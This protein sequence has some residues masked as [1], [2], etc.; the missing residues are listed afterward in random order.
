[1]YALL[2]SVTSNLAVEEIKCRYFVCLDMNIFYVFA[3]LKLK[4]Q[5]MSVMYRCRA[6]NREWVW[7][8]TSAFAFINPFS[9]DVEYIVCTNT[10]AK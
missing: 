7:L 4:G 6:K 2:V 9:E 8:R 1:M 3:V 10:S 5:V